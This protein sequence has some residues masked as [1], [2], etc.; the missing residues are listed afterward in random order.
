MTCQ[1]YWMQNCFEEILTRSGRFSKAET[2]LDGRLELS[3]GILLNRRFPRSQSEISHTHPGLRKTLHAALSLGYTSHF[4]QSQG[5]TSR[6]PSFHNET[7]LTRFFSES[8]FM[9]RLVSGC[10]FTHTLVSE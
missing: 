1:K 9:H 8:N 6:T 4:A 5:E 7:S 3:V 10:N 2:T